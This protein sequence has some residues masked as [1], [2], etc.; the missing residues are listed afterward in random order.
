M[1]SLAGSTGF[2]VTFLTSDGQPSFMVKGGGTEGGGEVYAGNGAQLG[3]VKRPSIM[4]KTMEAFDIQGVSKVKLESK[5]LTVL[6]L[7]YQISRQ[8]NPVGTLKEIDDDVIEKILGD[9]FCRYRNS[10]QYAFINGYHVNFTGD[11]DDADK[12]FVFAA[13]YSLIHLTGKF[14]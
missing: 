8:G 9:A 5:S 3:T 6:T 4:S 13:V 1:G 12:A 14:V 11:V 2:N 10:G 7:N